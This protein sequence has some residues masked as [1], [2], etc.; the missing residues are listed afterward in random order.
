[1]SGSTENRAPRASERSGGRGTVF[2]WNAASRM[3]P[4][5]RHIV[6]DV[7]EC[8]AR[9]ARMQTEKDR[10][11]RQRHRLAWPERARRYQLDEDIAGGER[12]MRTALG[13]LE[14]LG[15]TLVDSTKGQV[16]FPTMVQKQR[17]FFSWA[18]GEETLGYWHYTEDGERRP[19]PANWTQVETRSRKKG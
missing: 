10:L 17:A 19:I 3:L 7:M 9:L 8:Q 5:V 13:E 2:S 14:S 11:D 6:D 18:P 1:M 4:L 15:L 12:Q 16:G